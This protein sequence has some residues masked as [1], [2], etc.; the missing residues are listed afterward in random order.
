MDLSHRRGRYLHFA[1]R[2]PFAPYPR[3]LKPDCSMVSGWSDFRRLFLCYLDTAS[4]A[5]LSA[6]GV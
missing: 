3:D 5:T 4:V 1:A 2:Y 6:L